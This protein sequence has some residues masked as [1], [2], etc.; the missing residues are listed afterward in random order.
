MTTEKIY[1]NE[2]GVLLYLKDFPINPDFKFFQVNIDSGVPFED[3]RKVFGLIFPS[4][5]YKTGFYDLPQGVS[6]E[7]RQPCKIECICKIGENHRDQD[8][9]VLIQNPTEQP[10]S[11]EEKQ[12]QKRNNSNLSAVDCYLRLS[13]ETRAFE[14]MSDDDLDSIYFIAFGRW[15]YHLTRRGY[16]DALNKKRADLRDDDGLRKKIGNIL[17][18]GI[19]FSEQVGK[20]VITGA[21]DGI[22]KVMEERESSAQQ[23]IKEL[24]EQYNAL[25]VKFDKELERWQDRDANVMEVNRELQAEIE[26]LKKR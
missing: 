13:D 20:Y 9:A 7:V 22:V 18:D 14:S 1:V 3:Q 2:E 25:G 11:A 10:K 21:I 4:G 6:V 16:I 24:E 5:I 15:A 26:K 12:E 17:K 23:R 19:T 8:Y